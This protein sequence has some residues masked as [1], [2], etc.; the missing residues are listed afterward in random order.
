M[1]MDPGP[2]ALFTLALFPSHFGYR[3]GQQDVER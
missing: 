1:G 3:S 2:D